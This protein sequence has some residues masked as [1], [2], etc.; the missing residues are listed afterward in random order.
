VSA[1]GQER[2]TVMRRMN[3]RSV[4][5]A[6]AKANISSLEPLRSCSWH[7]P[8]FKMENSHGRYAQEKESSQVSEEVRSRRAGREPGFFA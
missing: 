2:W 4:N 3:V 5:S 8:T 7:A 1:A 6:Y